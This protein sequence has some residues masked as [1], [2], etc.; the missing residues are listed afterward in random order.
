MEEILH[1]LG[2]TKPCKKWNIDHI[3][4]LAG[5]LNHQQYQKIKIFF[6]AMDP[7]WQQE[8]GYIGYIFFNGKSQ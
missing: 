2:C 8:C 3:N 4:W 6:L 7:K 1:H 5:F